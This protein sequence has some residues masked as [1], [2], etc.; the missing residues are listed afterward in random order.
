MMKQ[1]DPLKVDIAGLFMDKESKG[2]WLDMWILYSK[3]SISILY[4]YVNISYF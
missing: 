4:L 3:I 2:S 1:F